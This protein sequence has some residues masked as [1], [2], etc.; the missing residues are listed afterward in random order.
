VLILAMTYR[1]IF[2]LAHLANSMFLSRKSRTVG[3]ASGA[4]ARRWL[5]ATTSTLVGKS[6]HLSSEVY[7]AML[8]RGFRGEPVSFDSN[9]M[10]T[11]DY[12]AIGTVAL[13]C[14]AFLFGDRLYRGPW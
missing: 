1:Y 14:A 3:P 5:G 4:F 2:V 6:Y 12:L 9:K 11:R 8:S 10:R 7:L 13:G